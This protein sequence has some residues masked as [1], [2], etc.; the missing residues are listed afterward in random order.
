MGFVSKDQILVLFLYTNSA[1]VNIPR[2]RHL[3][4]Q[5]TY[6]ECIVGVVVSSCIV[7]F[8]V[9]LL[10]GSFVAVLYHKRWTLRYLYHIGRKTLNPYHP[11]EGGRINLDTD[12]YISYD[13]D[14]RIA[15]NSTLQN[16]I[17]DIIIPFIS[18]KGY[19]V[20]VREDI[21]PGERLSKEISNI[22]RRCKKT[23][24]F[25]TPG[26]CQDYWNTFEFNISVMEGIYTER[27]IVI[28]V[29]VGKF[30]QQDMS[31]EIASV[32]QARI[33]ERDVIYCPTE[34]TR[35]CNV[36]FRA[37]EQKLKQ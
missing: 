10:T 22:L 28:L 15:D 9:V 35:E 19:T 3:A 6:S 23:L 37:L 13:I 17:H 21:T 8:I 24:V 31:A 16:L 11:V 29:I 7:C 12:T 32:G 5:L 20:K 33:K 26:F 14:Y 36:F 30:R 2:I 18:D 34:L 1:C 4:S 27:M 25:L